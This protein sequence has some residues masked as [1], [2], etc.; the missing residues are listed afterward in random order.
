[1]CR[2]DCS[3]D[4]FPLSL[5]STQ[6][7]ARLGEIVGTGLEVQRFRPNILVETAD[8]IPFAEDAWVGCVLRAA[9]GTKLL[10]VDK[11][12]AVGRVK[13]LS[14]LTVSKAPSG[15]ALYEE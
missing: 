4:T 3:F 10:W 2:T 15:K 11:R 6:T 12:F 1:M 8:A 9:A 14:C 13:I 7:I 5:I